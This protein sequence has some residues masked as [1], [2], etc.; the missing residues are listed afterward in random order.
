MTNKIFIDS[1]RSG[2]NNPIYDISFSNGMGGLTGVKD[3]LTT[4]A[5]ELATAGISG[6]VELWDRRRGY[7][8]CGGDIERL[9]GLAISENE[10]HG[11]KVVKY[12]PFEMRNAPDD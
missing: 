7:A 4:G 10:R 6:R 8:R 1:I 2:S 3:P 11:P 5:R 12:V 9:S